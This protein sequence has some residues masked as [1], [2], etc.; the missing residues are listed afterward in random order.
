MGADEIK[1]LEAYLKTNLNK[2]LRLVA[3]PKAKDS[4]E[5][6]LGEEFFGVVY[7]DTED[8]DT[9]YQITISV[10]AEDL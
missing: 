2:N 8:G 4:V 1:R 7:K 5:I 9:A 3:R 10:L 6:M